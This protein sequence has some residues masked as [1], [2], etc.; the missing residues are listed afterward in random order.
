MDHFHLPRTPQDPPLTPPVPVGWGWES[1]ME[2]VPLAV[3]LAA[4]ALSLGLGAV[5][6]Q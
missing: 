5:F 4:L 3:F 2:L 1:L 6:F